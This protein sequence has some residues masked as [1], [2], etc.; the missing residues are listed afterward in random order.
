MEKLTVKF[1]NIIHIL[2][3]SH[4]FQT[5]HLNKLSGGKLN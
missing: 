4:L 5:V 1:A 2:S 3:Y